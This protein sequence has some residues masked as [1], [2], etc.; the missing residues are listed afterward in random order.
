[1]I[2]QGKIILNHS[3]SRKFCVFL[4]FEKKDTRRLLNVQRIVNF[5]FIFG[6]RQ[7]LASLSNIFKMGL[8]A[9]DENMVK[10]LSSNEA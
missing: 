6:V 1:M 4:M 9:W 8:K 5:K 3:L 2:Q 10:P 7:S